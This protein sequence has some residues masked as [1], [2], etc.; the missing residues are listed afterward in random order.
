LALDPAAVALAAFL[1]TAELTQEAEAA[2]SR[3][4]AEARH[5]F[6]PSPM[7]LD[8]KVRVPRKERDVR[9]DYP[10][11][12]VPTTGRGTWIGEALIG[13]DGAV[14][15]VWVIAEITFEP[16]WPEFN[17]AIPK[18]IG[19]WKYTPTMLDGRAVPVC[20]TVNVLIHWK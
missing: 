5:L 11:R 14:A 6:S 7:L 3:C 16:P 9:P 19:R 10:T 4:G 2:H 13:P 18:A 8:G 15:R 17:A 20:M 12:S 1:G